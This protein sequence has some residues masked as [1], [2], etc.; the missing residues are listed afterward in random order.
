LEPLVPLRRERT[1]MVRV[2]RM[3]DPQPMACFPTEAEPVVRHAPEVGVARTVLRAQRVHVELERPKHGERPLVLVLLV[4]ALPPVQIL[5]EN[6]APC[7]E[8]HD[9]EPS[10]A[11]HPQA[12]GC[13]WNGQGAGAPSPTASSLRLTSSRR[14]KNTPV[15]DATGA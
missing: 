13:L 5:A 1:G 6:R 15:K 9:E 3:R 4:E 8:H 7:R 12:I 10:P 11:H 2:D 14:R